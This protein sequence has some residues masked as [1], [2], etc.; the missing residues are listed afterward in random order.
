MGFVF[1]ETP[2][3][4]VIDDER[5]SLEQFLSLIK[6]INGSVGEPVGRMVAGIVSK[7]VGEIAGMVSGGA[8]MLSG[9]ALGR[10]GMPRADQVSEN[11]QQGA[12]NLIPETEWGGS[13][14]NPINMAMSLIGKGVDAL[15]PNAPQDP[16]SLRGTMINAQRE[17]VPQA[18]GM[19]GVKSVPKVANSVGD[20]M[21][22]AAQS[23]M[24]NA[25]KPTPTQIIAGEGQLAAKELL[26]RGINPNTA[27]AVKIGNLVS[28]L[29][30]QVDNI[31]A[32]S[33]GTINKQQVLS[34]LARPQKTFSA[35]VNKKSDLA[36]IKSV[37]DE[38]A[39]QIIGNNIPIQLA[40]ELKRGT[41]GIL[42]KKFG[43][44]GTAAVEAQKS[45]AY[46]LRKGIEQ[47]EPAVISLNAQQA[48]LLTT[49]NLVERR[50]ALELT[51]DPL[52][53]SFFYH[54]PAVLAA[55]TANKSSM[56]KAV[57]AQIVNS[58]GKTLSNSKPTVP[59]AMLTLPQSRE[60]QRG[61]LTGGQ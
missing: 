45:L 43:E 52:A 27:G 48:K 32:N 29:S 17:I 40:Q 42:A 49:L 18:V 56:F 13:Q 23:L 34:A 44:Q 24:V 10:M 2:K 55:Y 36:A 47:A 15:R 14:Y 61:M 33:N 21:Q 1:E 46:G 16:T 58:F 8:D 12:Q 5:S 28:D 11:I 50:S 41:Q 35:Q 51:K 7:P 3:R 39:D 26:A 53:V 25:L 4:F 30:S 38:F 60:A 6:N 31:I 57:V 9:G 22:G 20:G 54:N 37:G 59:S 19:L